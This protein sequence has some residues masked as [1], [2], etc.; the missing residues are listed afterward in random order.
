MELILEYKGIF[1]SFIIANIIT[2]IFIGK[3]K[4]KLKYYITELIGFMFLLFV[5]HYLLLF[6]TEIGDKKVISIE[7]EFVK[8]END[9]SNTIYYI[10]FLLDPPETIEKQIFSPFKFYIDKEKN[11]FQAVYIPR[12][13]K[14]TYN[15]SKENKHIYYTYDSYQPDTYQQFNLFKLKLEPKQLD[16]KW[17]IVIHLPLN[18]IVKQ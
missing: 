10:F 14:I 12:D 3:Q 5:A 4:N 13:K 7:K 2:F 11:T 15:I 18:T 9:K 16:M 8:A 1:L 17:N 6:I